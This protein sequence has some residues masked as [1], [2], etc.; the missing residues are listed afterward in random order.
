[1]GLGTALIFFL[2]CFPSVFSS[3]L[4]LPSIPPPPFFLFSFPT[5]CFPLFSFWFLSFLKSHYCIPLMNAM[6][7]PICHHLFGTQI[8]GGEALCL[9]TI[10]NSSSQA[11]QQAVLMA[12]QCCRKSIL[13]VVLDSF[14]E[15]IVTHMFVSCFEDVLI[16]NPEGCLHRYVF[17]LCGD[18]TT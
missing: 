5:W 7:L 1:M 13:F 17:P 12:D 18:G 4:A 15:C 11:F 6:M 8:V 16:Q 10:R 9:L 3:S 14:P 2:F